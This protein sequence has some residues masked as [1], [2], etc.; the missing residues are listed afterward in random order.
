[1]N[2]KIVVIGAGISGLTTAYLLSK[3]GFDVKVI[4]KNRFCWWINRKCRLK[5]V[6]Y[7]IVDQTVP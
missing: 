3:K 7:L 5:M 2:K 1:M 6:S 4:E